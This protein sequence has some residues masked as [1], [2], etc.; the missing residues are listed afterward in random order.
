[1]IGAAAVLGGMARMTIS[2]TVILLECTG[3]EQFVL[4][5]ML[6][7]MTARIVGSLWNEDLY[8]IHIHLKK[9]VKFLESEL[10]SITRHH[11][12]VAGQIM[13]E[14]VIFV[15]PVDRVG[16]IYDI[17]TS[18]KHTNFPVVDTDDNGILYGTIGR[19]ALVILLQQR[20]FG[21]PKKESDM[22]HDDDFSANYLRVE[23]D[24]IKYFPLVQ[25]DVVEKSYPKYPSEK[26]LRI[27]RAERDFLVDLRPYANRAPLTVQESSTV[28]VSFFTLL[29]FLSCWAQPT[30]TFSGCNLFYIIQRTYQLFRSIGLRFLPVVNPHN[31]C[32]G[33]I[34]RSD[35]T[36]EA[37]ADTMLKKGK[38]R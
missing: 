17:L 31:Q 12:L 21:H 28:S 13:G 37:L 6:T 11:N 20:A 26:S 36:P 2:L 5:L 4:P 10:R 38:K 18:C 8:H 7:L 33:T 35:L 29:C 25:W 22:D 34:T 27:S 9:G 3:N 15:R 32:V 30:L 24:D 14:N 1:L 23:S 16:V 19:N